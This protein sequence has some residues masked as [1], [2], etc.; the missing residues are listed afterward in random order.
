MIKKV[1]SIINNLIQIIRFE[2]LKY[3]LSNFCRILITYLLN[4]NQLESYNMVYRFHFKSIVVP[5][6]NSYIVKVMA[7]YYYIPSILEMYTGYTTMNLKIK[8]SRQL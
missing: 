6:L 8:V 4:Y 5:Q 2:I 3:Q 7:L 1:S